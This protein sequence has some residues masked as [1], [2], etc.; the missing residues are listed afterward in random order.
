[1][2]F[3]THKDNECVDQIARDFVSNIIDG[4]ESTVKK[5]LVDAEYDKTFSC[6][7]LGI[8]Q[9]FSDE[10]KKSTQEYLIKA[11]NIPE[12]SEGEEYY[13]VKIEGHF[14]CIK[15]ASVYGM[16]QN[17]TVKVPNG[18]WN[19]MYISTAGKVKE[20]N[21]KCTDYYVVLE[22]DKWVKVEKTDSPQSLTYTNTIEADWSSSN[23]STAP[24]CDI[25]LTYHKYNRTPTD[26]YVAN[27]LFAWQFITTV[28]FKD[29]QICFSS[30]V[31]PQITI[32]VR[33]KVFE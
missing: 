18:D 28:S 14:Y 27:S 25:D 29:K 22:S 16:E 11:H 20:G 9:V 32:R 17:V 5:K 19:K 24:I 13:T 21:V 4:T 31:E 3:K 8:N 6:N 2:P 7:I 10:V 15:Q 12:I 23:F 30:L 33:V 26:M 1:M